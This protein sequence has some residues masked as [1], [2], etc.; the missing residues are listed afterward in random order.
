MA[1]QTQAGELYKN[2]RNMYEV[3][4]SSYADL[5]NKYGHDVDSVITFK[6][7]FTGEEG[8]MPEEVGDAVVGAPLASAQNEDAVESQRPESI[9]PELW[10][11]MVERM[12]DEE[13]RA[14]GIPVI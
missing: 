11:K 1:F 3:T 5:A 14:R 2:Q 6:P 7:R 10:R 13:K 12:T 8:G 9:E 4:A